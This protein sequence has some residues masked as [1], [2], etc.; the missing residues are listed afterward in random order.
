MLR[1]YL[2]RLRELAVDTGAPITFGQFSR[3]YAPDFW[4]PYFATADEAVRMLSFVPASH[5]GLSG[6]GLLRAGWAAD[7]IVFDPDRIAPLL[8]ELVYDLPAGA[9]RLKQQSTGLLVTVVNSEVRR[10]ENEHTGALPGQ[11]L[12]GPLARKE[13]GIWAGARVMLRGVAAAP[14]LRYALPRSVHLM[15]DVA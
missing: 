12:R 7:V 14:P 13:H 3:R 8:P 15:R 9:R 4:R 2:T 1:D 10:R 6:C 11:L 5:W